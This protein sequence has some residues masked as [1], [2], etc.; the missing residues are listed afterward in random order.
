MHSVV[1]S[2]RAIFVEGRFTSFFVA[3]TVIVMRI[4]LFY[5]NEIPTPV[6][7]GESFLWGYFEGFFHSP[8]V[9]LFAGTLSVF[10]IAIIISL[11]NSRFNLL[12]SRSALPFTIP[13][14][15]LSLHPYFLV[16]SG[17][18]I[19]VIFVLLA[20]FPL[21]ESYQK[22]DSYLYSFRASVLI[23]VASLFQIYAL[24]LLPLWWIGERL[25]RGPQV[26]SFI[27]SLFGVFL[28][29]LTLFSIFWVFVS[30]PLFLEP[31]FNF[32]A[33]SFPQVPQ[34]TILEWLAVVFVGLF[35]VTSMFF[36]IKIYGS[37]RALTLSLVQ[38]IV[39]LVVVLLIFFIL[40]WQKGAF[41]L[42][43][44]ISLTSYLSAYF[45]SKTTSVKHIYIAYGV[46]TLLF[47]FYFVHLVT[48]MALFL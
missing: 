31:F 28:V 3:L 46:F 21:I 16:M 17:D 12:H 33:L 19:S 32:G 48:A 14:F 29:Y 36:S 30:V 47:L 6:H 7:N 1:R 22:P 13:L 26:R 44:S 11:V 9:S 23:S 18:Y 25:M 34:F 8:Q 43:L 39:F 10:L 45:Y 27:A 15:L 4:A 37:D 41:F 5:A 24:L 40:Y 20:F 2:F 42:L 35:F 38:F